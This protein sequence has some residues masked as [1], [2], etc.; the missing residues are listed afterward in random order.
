MET[1]DALSNSFLKDHLKI[2]SKVWFELDKTFL[3]GPGNARLMASLIETKNLTMAAKECGYSY[4]YAWKKLKD[5]ER[6]IGQSIVIAKKG[7]YGGGGT[8]E[9]TSWGQNFL[10]IFTSMHER[11]KIFMESMNQELQ[12]SLDEKI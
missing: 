12:K 1:N 4:K 2:V 6:K 8:V 5:I 9:I 3:L 7:G 10:Q 11:V